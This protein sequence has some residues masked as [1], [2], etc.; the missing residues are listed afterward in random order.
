MIPKIIHYC[1][2]GGNPLPESAI[3]C[4]ESWKKFFPGYTI[5][6]WNESNFDFNCNA[7]VR[8]A[9]E[10]KKWAFVSDY[11]RFWILYH[12][13]G[14]YF[15]TDVEVIKPF[16]DILSK[17][18]FMG[19]EAVVLSSTKSNILDFEESNTSDNSDLTVAPGL[20]IATAP[21]LQLYKEIL[22]FYETLHFIREGVMDTTTICVFTTN[23]LKKYGY[24]ET[25]KKIQRVAGITIYP[26]D[27]F[28][29]MN[30]LTGEIT[31]TDNTHSIHW[32]GASWK[33]DIES[34]IANKRIYYVR[35][36]GRK[37]GSLYFKLVTIPDRVK[38]AISERGIVGTLLF[39]GEKIKTFIK[40]Q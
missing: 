24:D 29:P 25:E 33:S 18:G 21:G 19:Q 34:K 10:A 37:K 17:G 20:G 26:P 6:E 1:W 2:F 11:A 36:Y 38:R 32:Y 5:V 8:E 23:I 15:D 3:K 13:G 39:I 35:K 27:Y 16:D 30:Y 40:L 4:I 22:D 7:Y 31:L 12:K 9:Y 14:L 28:C